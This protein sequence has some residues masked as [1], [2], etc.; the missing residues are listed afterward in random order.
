MDIA[1][2]CPS[3][4]RKE[5]W[6]TTE[7]TSLRHGGNVQNMGIRY[8]TNCRF[9]QV[10]DPWSTND[11]NVAYVCKMVEAPIV[12]WIAN[13]QLL[14][15][16]ARQESILRIRQNGDWQPPLGWKHRACMSFLSPE[17]TEQTRLDNKRFFVNAIDETASG[18]FANYAG[19]YI[20]RCVSPTSGKH[21]DYI[22]FLKR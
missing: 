16:E 5:Q 2:P 11:N 3:C 21:F 8:C 9:V 14:P 15:S 19:Y 4:E 1:T 7:D 18:F 10:V 13:H 22:L 12:E 17:T 20:L 6:K